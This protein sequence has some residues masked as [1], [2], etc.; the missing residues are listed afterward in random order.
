MHAAR[1]RRDVRGAKNGWMLSLVRRDNFVGSFDPQKRARE[2]ERERERE[3]ERKR[4]VSLLL[5]KSRQCLTDAC[6]LLTRRHLVFSHDGFL[7]EYAILQD[8]SIV[9]FYP[10]YDLVLT[11]GL[12]CQNGP[13]RIIKYNFEFCISKSALAHPVLF[14]SLAL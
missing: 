9:Y 7:S 4:E 5:A 10:Y 13:L 6:N 8:D 2:S 12:G 11:G 3:R 1:R 14:F